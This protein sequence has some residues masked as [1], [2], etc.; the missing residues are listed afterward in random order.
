MGVKT[1]TNKAPLKERRSKSRLDQE[2]EAGSE[3][4]PPDP[5]EREFEEFSA[6]DSGTVEASPEF[7]ENLRKKL[8]KLVK[9]LYGLWVLFVGGM[10]HY[11]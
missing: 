9:S 1:M 4:H 8:M 2:T 6:A 3:G 5:D 11:N 7:K 10:T